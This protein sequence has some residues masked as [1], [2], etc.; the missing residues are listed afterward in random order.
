MYIY[1]CA[2]NSTHLLANVMIIVRFYMHR[3]VRCVHLCKARRQSRIFAS[4][5]IEYVAARAFFCVHGCWFLSAICAVFR[6]R[7]LNYYFMLCFSCYIGRLFH[8]SLAFGFR[9]TRGWM[10][11]GLFAYENYLARTRFSRGIILV[12]L[13]CTSAENK[14]FCFA[15]CGPI[16]LGSRCQV[17]L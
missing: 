7:W 8:D 2:H 3:C 16:L 6:E 9:A 1:I 10:H 4:Q 14:V 17:L 15:I 12:S 5:E 11:V 13:V